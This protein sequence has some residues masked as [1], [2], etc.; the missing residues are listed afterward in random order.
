MS[1]SSLVCSSFCFHEIV[2]ASL[3]PGPLQIWL[4]GQMCQLYMRITMWSGLD[5]WVIAVG[6]FQL[7][8]W[9]PVYSFGFQSVFA[10]THVMPR[11]SYVDALLTFH[12]FNLLQTQMQQFF[13]AVITNSHKSVSSISPLY[14]IIV[15]LCACLNPNW[16]T[17]DLPFVQIIIFFAFVIKELIFFN[18][19]TCELQN[20]MWTTK[21]LL[22]SN[23]YIYHPPPTFR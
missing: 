15:T 14:L 1:S 4:W 10:F 7:V 16:Y 11:L 2:S 3:R 19:S 18:H 21:V 9:V 23:S 6:S 22:V 13:M 12:D 8:L 17:I 20:I 5:A